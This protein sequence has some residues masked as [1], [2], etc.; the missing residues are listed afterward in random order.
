MQAVLLGV[1]MCST[2]TLTWK[3]DSIEEDISESTPPH[4]PMLSLPQQILVQETVGQKDQEPCK[5]ICS[6]PALPDSPSRTSVK[7]RQRDKVETWAGQ[8]SACFSDGGIPCSSLLPG[9]K[10]HHPYPGPEERG[11]VIS[12]LNELTRTLQQLFSP[13]CASPG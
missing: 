12:C 3:E 9:G 7:R 13:V 2:P 11:R 8:L 1:R 4:D 5:W 10:H 6:P